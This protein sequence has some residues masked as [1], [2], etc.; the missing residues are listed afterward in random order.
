MYKNKVLIRL[1][2][3]LITAQAGG[4]RNDF[5]HHF[6]T[7]PNITRRRDTEAVAEEDVATPLSLLSPRRGEREA[8]RERE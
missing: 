8:E 5:H 2:T 4:K 3:N 7:P 1:K 6:L